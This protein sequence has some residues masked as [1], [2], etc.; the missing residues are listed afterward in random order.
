LSTAGFFLVIQ[1]VRSAV[2]LARPV[3]NDLAVYAP[4]R[5]VQ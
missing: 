3:P 5:L 2:I 1:H 4:K